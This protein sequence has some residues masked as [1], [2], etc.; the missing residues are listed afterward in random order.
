M[1]AEPQSLRLGLERWGITWLSLPHVPLLL[2]NH[3]FISFDWQVAVVVAEDVGVIRGGRAPGMGI[4][5]K[6]EPILGEE[7]FPNG[8]LAHGAGQAEH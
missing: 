3:Y 6:I 2:D 1:D 4:I 7:R 8:G 5:L